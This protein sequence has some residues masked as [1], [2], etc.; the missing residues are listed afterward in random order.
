MIPVGVCEAAAAVWFHEPVIILQA[1]A[2]AEGGW[3]GARIPDANGTADHGLMQINS[4]WRARL[5][6]QGWRMHTVQWHDCASVFVGAWILHQDIQ[7]AHNFWMGVAWYQSRNLQYG[8]PFAE[9]VHQDVKIIE[10]R[11][12]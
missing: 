2:K 4:V 12:Q 1:I 7:A 10:Q 5:H 3:R 8:L 9:T 6:A 11:G